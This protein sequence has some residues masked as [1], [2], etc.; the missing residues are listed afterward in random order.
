MSYCTLA[1]CW[2][3]EGATR[4]FSVHAIAFYINNF[5][6]IFEFFDEKKKKTLVKYE[7]DNYFNLVDNLLSQ[8]IAC[9]LF[10]YFEI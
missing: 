1:L 10:E 2:A 3:R 6:C 5:I 9:L 8:F 4:G 7:Y